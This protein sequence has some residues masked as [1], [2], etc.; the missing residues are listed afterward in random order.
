MSKVKFI[1]IIFG[2]IDVMDNVLAN[3]RYRLANVIPRANISPILAPE[4]EL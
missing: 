2:T 3:I 1:D 4:G